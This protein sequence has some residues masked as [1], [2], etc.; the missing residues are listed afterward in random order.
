MM[1]PRPT[2]HLL[3]VLLVILAPLLASAQPNGTIDQLDEIVQIESVM[4]PMPDGTRLATDVYLPITGDSLVLPL[5]IPGVGTVE[6]EIVPRGMQY[7][8]Y[9]TLNGSPN[10]NPYQLPFVF[11]RT[12]YDKAGGTEFIGVAMALLGYG[13]VIQDT[14]GVFASE[15]VFYPLMSD[16]WAK[17]PYMEDSI[18]I[19][20]FGPSHPSSVVNHEDGVHTL[21]YVLN[22][23]TRPFDLDDDGTIDLVD[24]ACNGSVGMIGASALAMPSYQLSAA[25]PIDP[26]APGLKGLLN[27][28]ASN[29]HYNH[30]VF[31]NGVFREKLVQFWINGQM[32]DFRDSD[33]PFD[34][35]RYNA[36]HTAADYAVDSIDNAIDS[37]LNFLTMYTFGDTLASAY[38]NAPF[39]SLVDASRA[40]VDANGMGQRYGAFSRYRNAEVPQYHFSGWYDIFCSGQIET[41]RNLRRELTTTRDQQFLVIGPWAHTTIATQSTGDATYPSNVGDVLGATL[42]I[43]DFDIANLDLDIDELINSEVLS[44]F[45]YTLNENGFADVGAPQIRFPES[46]R[47]QE[48]GIVPNSL[49]RLPASDYAISH[50]DLINWLGAF[51]PLPGMPVEVAQR[52]VIDL[53]FVTFVDTV[54]VGTFNIDVPALPASLFDLAGGL[55]APVAG[56]PAPNDFSSVPPVR[57]YII[58]PQD[59]GVPGNGA[60]GDYWM[61]RDSFPFNTGIHWNRTFLHGDGTIDEW[62]PDSIE[63]RVT[64]VHDPD[65]PVFTVGGHNM[66]VDLPDGRE[67]RGQMDLAD[68]NYAPITMDHPGVVS[69][70]SAP[71]TDTV[72]IVGYPK[73]RLFARST[74]QGTTPGDPTDTDFFVR[75]VDVYPDGRELYVTEGVVNARARHYAASIAEGGEDDAAPFSNIPSD[76]VVEYFFDMLPIGYT[77]GTDHRIKVLISS[78][79]HPKYQSNPN[80]PLEDGEFFRRRVGD[81]RPYVFQG[82]PYTARVADQAVHFAP[83]HPSHIWWPVFGRELITCQAPDS[84]RV[85]S[86]GPFRADLDWDPVPGAASYRVVLTPGISSAVDTLDVLGT[87]LVV[88]G[89]QQ[90]TDYTWAVLPDCDDQTVS[91]PDSFRTDEFCPPVDSFWVVEATDSSI[92]L[93]WNAVDFAPG[94]TL[95]FGLEGGVWID[96]MAADTMI[97]LA[98]QDDTTYGFVVAPICD[99]DDSPSDTLWVT[100]PATPVPPP[101]TTSIT[102]LTGAVRLLPV[103]VGDRLVIESAPVGTTV[104]VWSTTGRQVLRRTT[105]GGRASLDATAWSP[106]V[107]IVVMEDGRGDR[108]VRRIVKR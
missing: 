104:T 61:A 34:T 8:H 29:E 40:P 65:D 97:L 73:V 82:T 94:Y 86:V 64:Y 68:P 83:E 3:A 103:P 17:A 19:D 46:D 71:L 23:V 9:P 63:P 14:R 75:V 32:N 37:V 43:Q 90:E 89:L 18:P 101:D 72:S 108:L 16:G 26:A 38:P 36:I 41:W 96:T 69:F 85:D 52:I 60:A 91:L 76:S 25:R 48:A 105:A 57:A 58:G 31:T 106:G 74:P 79:N 24:V 54:S 55:D 99:T 4:L 78:S 77:F 67:S 12:P 56:F 30:T 42:D 70:E 1:R 5:P 35:S 84:L 11:V 27:L 21:D 47:Y 59:D 93:A 87:D 13:T 98:A 22:G 80:I 53:G 81:T 107:Y 95:S 62:A 39:R 33:L 49:I 6:L 88:N 20:V 102:R 28:I 44:W 15:G 7:I 2:H 92:S 45:R 10:P 50:A 51:G 66:L 100:T